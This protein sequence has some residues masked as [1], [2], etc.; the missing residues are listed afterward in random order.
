MNILDNSS[1]A[2]D[3]NSKKTLKINETEIEFFEGET[4][5]EVARKAD[6]FIP[7]LCYIENLTPYGACRLCIVKVDG[8]KGYPTACSTPA[9]DNMKII[10]NDDE[11]QELRREV[12]KL[13]LS[14]HPYSCL[15]CDNK[16]KCEEDGRSESKA[17]R[18]FGCFFCSSKETCDLR[19]ITKDV[20]DSIK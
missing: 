9:Q 10:T 3:S 14:E 16:N 7:T 5:L 6:I 13:I 4:I 8:M 11:L 18:S 20:E 17:G 2:P 15:V 19:K 1:N 12:L